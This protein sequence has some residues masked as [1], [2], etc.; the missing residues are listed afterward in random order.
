M[1]AQL[2]IGKVAKE[3]GVNIQTLRYY[4][5]RGMI[6][7]VS[8]RDSGYRLYGSDAS[9]RIRFIK[10][11]QELGFTLREISELLKL[12]VSHRAR[13]GDVKKK[14]ER[15]LA[16]VEMKMRALKAIEAAL[17]ELIRKC[18]NEATT[19]DCP[20]LR[21]LEIDTRQISRKRR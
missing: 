7:P 3:A 19:D 5:R 16:D 15:K 4:E 18:R 1:D 12:K 13:C 21:S 9:H 20:I 10:R 6:Q 8:R 17:K 14:A 11:A 2:T